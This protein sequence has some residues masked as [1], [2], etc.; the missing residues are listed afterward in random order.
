MIYTGETLVHTFLRL[1][2]ISF[3]DVVVGSVWEQIYSPFLIPCDQS[4][5]AWRHSPKIL[6]TSQVL[7]KLFC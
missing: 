7:R 5:E 2:L 3:P 1:G 6:V 4:H